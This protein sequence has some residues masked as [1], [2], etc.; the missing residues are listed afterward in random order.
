MPIINID[1]LFHIIQ[2]EDEGED[3]F[4]EADPMVKDTDHNFREQVCICYTYY[5]MELQGGVKNYFKHYSRLT[6]ACVL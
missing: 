2:M 1:D 4:S 5:V 3:K 6:S